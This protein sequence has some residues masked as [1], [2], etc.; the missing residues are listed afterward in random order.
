LGIVS[1][2][3]HYETSE[4]WLS[5]DETFLIRSGMTR[6]EVNRL[7]SPIDLAGGIFFEGSLLIPVGY[8]TLSKDHYDVVFDDENQVVA[9]YKSQRQN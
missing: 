1:S 2:G 5:E 8:L 3:N 9:V 6:E 4:H 7:A